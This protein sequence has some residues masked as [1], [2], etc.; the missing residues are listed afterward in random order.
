MALWNKTSYAVRLFILLLGYSLVMVAGFIAFQY[1]REKEFKIE[2][3]NLRLQ[4]V[5]ERILSDLEDG[6][7][8]EKIVADLSRS[9]STLRV[10]VINKSGV[11]IYDNFMTG[12]KNGDHSDRAEII[13]A[14]RNG[15]S[16]TVRRNSSSTGV[17]YFYSATKG[18]DGL[19]VRTALPYDVSLVETLKADYGFLKIMGAITMLMCLIGFF[20]TK[21]IGSHISRLSDF[22]AKAERGERIYEISPFPDDELGRISNNIVRLYARLQHVMTERDREHREA[23]RQQREKERIKKQLTNNINHEL[24]TPVASIELCLETLLA[25][26]EMDADKRRE[27]LARCL[28]NAD[29]LKRLLAD[30]SIITRIDDGGKAILMEEIDLAAVVADVEAESTPLASPRGMLIENNIRGNIRLIGNQSLLAS[31]FRNLIDNAIS[32]SGGNKISLDFVI[33]DSNNIFL[34][35][36]DN[37]TGVPDEHLAHLFERFYRIDKGRSALRAEPVSVSPL[38]RMPFCCMVVRS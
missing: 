19:I 2:E 32:Y 3:L 14:L 38:S 26:E 21:R 17:T 12:P 8:I 27:F 6:Q 5:N 1:H 35:V 28:V 31:V 11:M 25:H 18:P 23:L 37:G 20:A 33:D 4:L 9:A 10:S 7:T 29:R 30:V 24:K 34:T 15:N 13:G 36:A 22:A 16:Y